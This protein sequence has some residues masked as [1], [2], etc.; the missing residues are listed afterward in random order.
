M[1]PHP[2]VAFVKI[3]W[4]ADYQGEKEVKVRDSIHDG[5]SQW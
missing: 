2:H 5:A 4:L 1:K 3:V